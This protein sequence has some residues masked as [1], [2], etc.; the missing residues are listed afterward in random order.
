MY[1]SRDLNAI[2]ERTRCEIPNSEDIVHI[3]HGSQYLST[4][5]LD[6]AFYPVELEEKS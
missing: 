2:T 5:Y 4:I 6:N 1:R 3:L